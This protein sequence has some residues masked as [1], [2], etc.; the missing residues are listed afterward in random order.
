MKK[1]IAI[2]VYDKNDTLMETL[3]PSNMEEKMNIVEYIWSK[4]YLN[5]NYF[6][7]GILVNR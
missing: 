2:E 7:K 1:K 5:E 4:G 3:V 6:K